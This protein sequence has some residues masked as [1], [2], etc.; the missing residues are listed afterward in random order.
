[1][2]KVTGE[3]YCVVFDLFLSCAIGGKKYKL[4]YDIEI[5]TGYRDIN[6]DQ[7]YFGD[8]IM[9]DKNTY[10]VIMHVDRGICAINFVFVDSIAIKVNRIL[11][12]SFFRDSEKIKK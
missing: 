11:P 4:S 7:I 8:K 12:N 2:L 1:M 5:P 9:Y 10:T 3:Q 6:A